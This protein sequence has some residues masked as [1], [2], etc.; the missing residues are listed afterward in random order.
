MSHQSLWIQIPEILGI[1]LVALFIITFI[2]ASTSAKK[3]SNDQAIDI[4]MDLA[5]LATGA[6]GSVFANDTLVQKWG[7]GLIVYG[8]LVVLI[9]ISF[10]AGFAYTRRWQVSPVSGGRATG[11]IILGLIP[12]GLVTAILVLGYTMTP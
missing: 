2:K 5:I 11:N 7:M 9:C 10:V 1:P 12:V 8:I 6:A 4:A 3:I